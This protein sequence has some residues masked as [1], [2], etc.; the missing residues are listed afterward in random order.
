MVGVLVS[1]PVRKIEYPIQIGI[2]TIGMIGKAIH[3]GKYKESI[4]TLT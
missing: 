3:C 2:R 4:A 1:I